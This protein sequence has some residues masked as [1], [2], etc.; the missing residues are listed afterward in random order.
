MFPHQCKRAVR[1][2]A[3]PRSKQNAEK[4]EH[5]LRTACRV[6][7]SKIES[8]ANIAEVFLS[9][10]LVGNVMISLLLLLAS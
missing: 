10:V 8:P 1:E 5:M 2:G 7:E 9:S 3:L 6:L 4:M